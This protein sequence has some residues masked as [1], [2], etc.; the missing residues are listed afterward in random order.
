MDEVLKKKKL[1]IKNYSDSNSNSNSNSDAI[2]ALEPELREINERN[3][4]LNFT[5]TSIVKKE[6]DKFKN[7]IF[8]FLIHDIG[9]DRIVGTKDDVVKYLEDGIPLAVRPFH[10][11][12]I[13][14]EVPM[15]DQ[16]IY[17]FDHLILL[18]HETNPY[19]KQ[20]T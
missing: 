20:D 9:E 1:A 11:P 2:L 19:R 3:G 8:K 14:A 18:K 6:F 7:I 4:A 13:I 12:L 17:E 5:R 15:Y 16:E 10:R